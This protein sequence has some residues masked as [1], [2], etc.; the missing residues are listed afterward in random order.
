MYRIVHKRQIYVPVN[1]V[2]LVVH[3]NHS[4]A[5]QTTVLPR[6]NIVYWLDLLCT[7]AKTKVI[8]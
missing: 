2:G 3:T 4:P 7:V 1:L 6:I 5:G 8:R